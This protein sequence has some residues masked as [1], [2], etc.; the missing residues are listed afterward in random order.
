MTGFGIGDAPLGEGRL[1]LELR[2]L[3]H[4]FLD[5]RVRVPTEL[6]DQTFFLEQLARERLSRGR[7]DVGVR[8]EG[9]ALPP[10]RFSLERARAVYRALSELRDELAPGTQVPVSALTHLPELVSGSASADMEAV[11]GSL[12]AAFEDALTRLDEMRLLEGQALQRE[13]AQRLAAV[14]T[15]RQGLAAASAEMLA[16]YR[17]RLSERLER[18]LRDASIRLDPGRIETEIAILADRSDVTEE[19]VRLA[20]HFDQFAKLLSNHEP[21]GRR[22]DFLL[23]EI[24]REANTVGS[25][26]QDAKLAHLVVEMKADVERMREQVQNVE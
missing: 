2:A 15:L 1:V 16:T 8:I 26:C 4:R 12:R 10:P 20:S 24:G 11:R 25:K 18:L 23:Q 9:T 6:A 14:E 13:L 21:V 17:A 7:F 19:L 5:V 22:L 3:N